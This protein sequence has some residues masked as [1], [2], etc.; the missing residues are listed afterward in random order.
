MGRTEQEKHALDDGRSDSEQ[1]RGG[2]IH[3]NYWLI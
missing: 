3:Q 1:W 2:Q